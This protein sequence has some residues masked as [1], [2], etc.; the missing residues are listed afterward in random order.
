M[1]FPLKVDFATTPILTEIDK[2]NEIKTVAETYKKAHRQ[3]IETSKQDDVNS[4]LGYLRELKDEYDKTV[5]KIKSTKGAIDSTEALQKLNLK[6]LEILAS[7]ESLS[8]T[9]KAALVR[10]ERVE[11]LTSAFTKEIAERIEN[12]YKID[13]AEILQ[14]TLQ[15][16]FKVISTNSR[17]SDEEKSKQI[18]V[19][20]KNVDMV[21]ASPSKDI[22]AN[23]SAIT[24]TIPVKSTFAEKAKNKVGD[25][26]VVGS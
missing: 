17:Q 1:V 16:T 3:I 10:E 18:K 15:N 5:M 12:L 8:K 2:A 23:L 24:N 20:L 6:F 21:L 13:H 26:L 19:L 14:K 9:D 11:Y 22:K 25:G 7:P 4:K